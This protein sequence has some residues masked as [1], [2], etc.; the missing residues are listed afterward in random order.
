MRRPASARLNPFGMD[1]AML[2]N[3][4]GFAFWFLLYTFGKS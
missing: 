3:P 4:N 1:T 2:D